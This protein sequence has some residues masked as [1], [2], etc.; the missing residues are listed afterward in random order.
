MRNLELL[1]ITQISGGADIDYRA[2]IQ[3]S[4][5][6]NIEISEVNKVNWDNSALGINDGSISMS[7]IIPGAIV[8]GSFIGIPVVFHVDDNGYAKFS[9]FDLI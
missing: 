8:K 5:G 1:E 4:Y 6:L 7:A 3:S 9:G 2:I